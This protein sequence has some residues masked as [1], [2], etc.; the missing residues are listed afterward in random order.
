MSGAPFR[1]PELLY[2]VPYN[3]RHLAFGQCSSETKP[4]QTSFPLHLATEKHPEMLNTH[5]HISR[6]WSYKTVFAF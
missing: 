2:L 5:A 1:R 4:D 6:N 3:A